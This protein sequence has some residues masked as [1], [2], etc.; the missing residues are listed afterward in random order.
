MEKTEFIFLLLATCFHLTTL[1]PIPSKAEDTITPPQFITG[2]QTLI[3][4]SQNFE[5]GFFTPKNSTYTY[6]GIWYKQIHIKNIVWVANRDKPLLDHNGTLTFNN[7]GKLIILNYGG[8]VLWAS[9]SS[10][11]AKTPVAQLLDTGNFVLKNFEDE[12]SEE[13]LWQ[14]FDY[15]SNTLL[16]GMKLGRN[17]KTGLN[18]HLTS[19]KNIDN[20]SSGEYSYSVDPRGLP[21]LFL[22]KG[23][24]KIFRSG[25]WYVEQY[26]GDPVLRENPIFKP[27][28][29]FDSDEVYYSFETKDDIVSRF[30]LS[31]SGLIQHF[32]W[33]DHRSNWFSEFNVQGDRCDDY[34]ICGAY[35]TCNIKNSPICKCL[36]G[37]EPRNMHDW[38][39][40]DWSSGCVRENSK[41]C[42]N[43]DVFKKFIGMKLP[44]SVEFHVNYSIN[45]DQ[46]EVEC[47]KNCSCVAY[48]KLDINASGNGCIAWFGDLFDI[49]EDSVNEQ[50]FFVRVSASELAK[51]TGIRLSVDTSKSEF[52]LPF[53]EIAIIEAA[54]RNFS[55][56]NKIGEGGFGPV[57]KGQLPSGQEIA[58][59]RLSENSGQGL[60]EF[61]NEVIFISQL[62][63][64]NLVKLLGC[65][66]QG[67]DKMLVYEY[68]P[69]RSLDSLLFDET[70]RS[71]LSWQKRL[72]II[73]G[74]ARGLVYLHRDS[75]LRIIHRDLKA[76]N[77]LLDGEMNPKI[78]DFGMARMFGGDQTE[79]K[80]KRVVGTY[81]YMPPEYAMDGHFSFKSDVYSF[82]VLLLELL[83]GKKNRGFFHPDHKLNLLGHAWKLWNEGKVIELMDPLLEDQVS[84]PESILK[85]IQIGLLCVQQ[86]PEER[87][88]MSSVVLMLDGE[89]VLLPKPRR[90]GLY[91]ERCFLETD[92][93]SRGMLNSGSND[94]TVTTTVV[95][96]RY[97]GSG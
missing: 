80:T 55:F 76:S 85:C 35:G 70:K 93:S 43:G 72:D 5:L 64:R 90:P 42:R 57:Y 34:G 22:Q 67:E 24:K 1:F 17:F 37:F 63:H 13:I 58:V 31:E 25:P 26:K 16:P 15:P 97:L 33:N 69:N 48:A 52:E 95:E 39:M 59:K 68:M 62:Q 89:S 83:S 14:S 30:V 44:D 20:P 78:S 4:P 12:N 74:I 45:I 40:L 9:N 49:R 29:V 92:S 32:T 46:C 88:T 91:S 87:P 36:N 54:T 77:V 65:C 47:S 82:G 66:I 75:R 6:L 86:H 3:S 94:I 11:P 73:D 38:K 18:I 51:E 23:K 27:V 50:D 8:S 71:A 81:G 53:F 84:T 28:F 61:K 60:Q 7:D 21:Q 96:G 41:V 56:Y 10:G 2:N 79:E 19:W